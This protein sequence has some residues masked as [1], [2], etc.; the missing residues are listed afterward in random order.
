MELM[1]HFDPGDIAMEIEHSKK[2]R[3][4]LFRAIAN[5][6][7]WKKPTRTRSSTSNGHTSLLTLS[8]LEG[9]AKEAVAGQ[10]LT[11][12]NYAEA[13]AM[14]ERRF[15]DKAKTNACHIEQ[16]MRLESVSSEHHLVELKRLYGKTESDI[17][18][19]K[20]MGVAADAYGT[21]FIS[22]LMK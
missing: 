4:D 18:G 3:D 17:T 21:L 2:I 16:F 5:I 6:E 22:I 11:D 10:A 13:I 9:T 7:C 14:P 12:V 8:L 15:G 19:L 1:P 20:N